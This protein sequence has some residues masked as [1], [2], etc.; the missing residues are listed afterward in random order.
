MRLGPPF[1]LLDEV[2]EVAEVPPVPAAIHS[3]FFLLVGGLWRLY[4]FQGQSDLYPLC[5]EFA[6]VGEV[7]EHDVTLVEHVDG[8]NGD[9]VVDHVALVHL[10]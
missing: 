1:A 9:S 8:I 10:S 2:D 6:A 7:V 4:L 3:L 5:I